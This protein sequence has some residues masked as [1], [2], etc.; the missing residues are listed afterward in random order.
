MTSHE[1]ANAEPDLER[2]TTTGNI[3]LEDLVDRESLKEVIRSFV[4]LFGIS[5]RIYS[6]GGE[7]LADAV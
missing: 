1:T 3:R 7:M 5:V 6:A 2:L 4:T